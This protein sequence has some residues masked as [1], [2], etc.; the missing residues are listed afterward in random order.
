[1]K[2][3]SLGIRAQDYTSDKVQGF[4]T[5]YTGKRLVEGVSSETIDHLYTHGGVLPAA[6][7]PLS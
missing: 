4:D 5:L 1:M 3:K 2:A 6:E 7:L